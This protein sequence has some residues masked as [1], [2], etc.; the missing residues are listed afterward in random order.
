MESLPMRE[1]NHPKFNGM[2]TSIGIIAL[3]ACGAGNANAASSASAPPQLVIPARYIPAY[4][5]AR[6][7]Y[8][9]PA[10][11]GGGDGSSA[12][13]WQT[14]LA[15]NDSGTL[16]AGD[17]VNLAAGV[18]ALSTTLTLNHGGNAN[19]T[20]GYVVYRSAALHGA[21]LVATAPFYQLINIRTAYV[22]V[23]G[24]D[25][26][27]NNAT[28]TGEAVGASGDAGYHHIVVENNLIHGA[29]GG[30]VQLNDSEYFW[31]IGNTIYGNAST[32]T[33]QESGIST[34]Q[35]QPASAFTATVADTA[36]PWHIVI[37]GN[38]SRDNAETYSCG[39]NPGC[40]TDGNGIIIDKTL[41][42]DRS[43]GVPYAGGVLV[44]GNVVYGNGGAGIQ[45]YLSEHV[46]IANNTVYDNHLDLDNTGTWRGELSS[47][48]SAD[49]AWVNNIA[50]AVPGSG[51]RSQNSAVLVAT[52]GS[53]TNA[54]VTWT[55]NLTFGA[56]VKVYSAGG[57]VDPAR[58]RS[59]IDPRFT[60]LAGKDFTLQAASPAVHSGAPE[61]YLIS[62]TP[63]IG[64][65]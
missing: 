49:I 9:D 59:N 14:P 39:A 23:D 25:I 48:D 40:H 17:C 56:P 5:C 41:N 3:A 33:Y 21:H 15:A 24:L 43:G 63:D 50:Y 28:S 35:A 11:P 55:G 44:A 1:K 51:V 27:G 62:A 30:G 52:T 45:A 10:A 20:G 6:N 22:I 34:Y 54:D 18:Y 60:N 29:G 57:A 2:F 65:Y 36:L 37:A 31:V 26:D 46:T 61:S 4:S 13:P 58:N 64:A 8:V 19:S 16:T 32:N 7:L 53:H 42:V 12:H 38:I 47:V